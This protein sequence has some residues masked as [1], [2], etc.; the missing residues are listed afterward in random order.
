MRILNGEV[1]RYHV[2][3]KAMLRSPSSKRTSPP[4]GSLSS[5]GGMSDIVDVLELVGA[6]ACGGG[7][8]G[9]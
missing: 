2:L 8:T 3:E 5:S 4:W 9:S 6:S 7:G 1:G